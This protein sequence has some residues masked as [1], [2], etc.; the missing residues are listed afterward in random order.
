LNWE[1]EIPPEELTLIEQYLLD[2]LPP[3]EREAF[4]ARLYQDSTLKAQVEEM[5]LLLV[6]IK[7]V[8][9]EKQLNTFH[10][11][12]SASEHQPATPAKSLS[13]WFLKIAASVVLLG[14]LA[15]WV[16][17]QSNGPEK[18]FATYYTPDPGLITAMSSSDN[19]LFDRAMVDYKTGQYE[20]AIKAWQGL[21]TSKPNNDTLQYFIGSAWLA[22]HEQEKAIPL[23]RKVSSAPTSGFWKEANWYLGL[24]LLK[25]G[26]TE[27]ALPYLEKSD[28]QEKQSLISKL[29]E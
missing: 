26:K 3:Q 25:E 27:E 2:E 7:E 10:R 21:S 9:L 8:S 29:K 1:Q 19:Y 12:L 28:H 20:A 16:I 5:R 24:A 11:E 4:T 13:P 23:F 22:L 18:L 14:A 6:G 15:W 17:S